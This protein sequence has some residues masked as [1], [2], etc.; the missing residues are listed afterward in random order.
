[1]ELDD[2]GA[3]VLDLGIEANF[4]NF[5]YAYKFVDQVETYDYLTNT[6][7]TENEQFFLNYKGTQFTVMAALS[8]AI[9]AEYVK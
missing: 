3:F 5:K 4:F 7:L 1:M 8:W 6:Y 9:D 2:D